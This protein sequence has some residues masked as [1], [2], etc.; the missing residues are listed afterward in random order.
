VNR[1]EAMDQRAREDGVRLDD[2]SEPE[3]LQRFRDTP[4]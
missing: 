3:L 2:L 4:R 1:F